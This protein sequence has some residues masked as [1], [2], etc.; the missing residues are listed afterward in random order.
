MRIGFLSASLSFAAIITVS[1]PAC[2]GWVNAGTDDASG[3]TF[4]YDNHKNFFA[5]SGWTAQ[6]I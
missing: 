3:V 6:S 2:A 1:T 5:A 4:Y